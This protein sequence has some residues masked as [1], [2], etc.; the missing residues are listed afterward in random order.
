MHAWAEPLNV[1]R[2]TATLIV[3]QRRPCVTWGAVILSA[4]LSLDPALV[5]RG[6]RRRFDSVSSVQRD[7]FGA[8]AHE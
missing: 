6:T 4:R 8:R 3:D 1:V 2:A 7:V 5:V